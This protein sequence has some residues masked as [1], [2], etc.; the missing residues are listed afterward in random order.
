M[1]LPLF[2]GLFPIAVI[3]LNITKSHFFFSS[4]VDASVI[5]KGKLENK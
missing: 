4:N 2:Y 1:L 5:L 3:A